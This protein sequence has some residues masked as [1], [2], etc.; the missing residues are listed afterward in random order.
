MGRLDA[1]HHCDLDHSKSRVSGS[2][3]S[4]VSV[5]LFSTVTRVRTQ[6]AR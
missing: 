6:N 1:D 4:G 5:T 3:Q 2:V